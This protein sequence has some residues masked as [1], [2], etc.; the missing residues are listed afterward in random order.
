MMASAVIYRK[1]NDGCDERRARLIAIRM[2]AL[3]I[4]AGI[5]LSGLNR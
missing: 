5:R 3:P 2:T 4:T 1:R